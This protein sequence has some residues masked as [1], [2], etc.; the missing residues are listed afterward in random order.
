VTTERGVRGLYMVAVVSAVVGLVLGVIS[1]TMGHALEGL[2]TV[3]YF[4]LVAALMAGITTW[5]KRADRARAAQRQGG[6][7]GSRRR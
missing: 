3:I 4:W 5:A 7:D 1:V 2:L 6:D